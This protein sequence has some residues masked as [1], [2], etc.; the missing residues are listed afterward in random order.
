MYNSAGKAG[1]L[2][3]SGGLFNSNLTV[4]AK[5]LFPVEWA[6]VAQGSGS[7]TPLFSASGVVIYS[8]QNNLVAGIPTLTY[9]IKE[10]WDIDLMGQLFFMEVQND[11][12]SLAASLFFRIKLSF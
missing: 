4:S 2:G 10:N 5:N 6:F 3:G 11:F 1:G 8:P 12:R 9:S 7:I